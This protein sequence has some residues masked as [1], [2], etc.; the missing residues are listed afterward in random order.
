MR[1]VG[2][3]SLMKRPP[4]GVRAWRSQEL[5]RERDEGAPQS[6]K[7]LRWHSGCRPISWSALTDG[8]SVTERIRVRRPCAICSSLASK[9]RS[10]TRAHDKA[11]AAAGPRSTTYARRAEPK[12]C[13]RTPGV[14]V[15]IIVKDETDDD[16]IPQ[17]PGEV[18]GRRPLRQP[19]HLMP[20]SN[21]CGRHDKEGE[22]SPV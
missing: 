19:A 1:K 12:R 20:I 7:I 16:G 4:A 21:W 22:E 11:M 13:G 17:V 9:H 14:T 10:E 2:P 3:E 5:S 15:R 8:W 18:F 6:G